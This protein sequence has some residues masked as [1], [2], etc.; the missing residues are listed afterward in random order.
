MVKSLN[1]QSIQTV[2]FETA[3]DLFQALPISQTTHYHVLIAHSYYGHERLS[4]EHI[5]CQ[6][7]LI[8]VINP[9]H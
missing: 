6:P 2:G 8:S 7:I 5:Q 1:F 4:F 3:D 9:G